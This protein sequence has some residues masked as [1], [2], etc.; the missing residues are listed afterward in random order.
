MTRHE[1]LDEDRLIALFGEIEAPAGVDSW[2]ERAGAEPADSH[3]DPDAELDPARVVIPLPERWLRPPRAH[4]RATAAVAAVVALVVGMGGVLI[5]SQVLTDAPPADPTMNI[6]GPDGT[7]TPTSPVTSSPTSQTQQSTQPPDS[8]GTAVRGQ[9]NDGTDG[10]SAPPPGGQPVWGP[11]SGYPTADNTGVPSGSTL[12]EHEG[13]LEINTPG[14]VVTDLR[15][16]G[17][18]WVNAPDVTLRRVVVVGVGG[19]N[20]VEQRGARLRIQDSE[21]SAR[22]GTVVSQQAAGLVMIRNE[23]LGDDFDIGLIEGDAELY[24]NYIAAAGVYVGGASDILLERNSFDLIRLD[25]YGTSITDVI[26]RNNS[27]R[28]VE[29]PTQPSSSRIHVLDNVFHGDAPSTGWNPDGPDWVWTGNT[30][31][32]TGEPVSP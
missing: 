8:A 27:L 2:R 9:P 31:G 16:S 26:I 21:L 11:M 20:A 32:D 15:V 5:V 19:T 4:R 12:T 29:A 30:Y 28:Q 23:V 6:D 17:T 7:G 18:V 1:P 10:G 22:K 25:D 13:D 24:E 3:T 14:A